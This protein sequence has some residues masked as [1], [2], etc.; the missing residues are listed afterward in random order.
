TSGTRDTVTHTLTFT[1]TPS[2]DLA[3]QQLDDQPPM[4][5]EYDQAG[6]RVRR[7]THTGSV[8]TWNHDYTGDVRSMSVDSHHIDFTH[9]LL[10][11]TTGWRTGD[12]AVSRIFTDNGYLATQE[13]IA[14]PEQTLTLDRKPNHPPPRSLRRDD[15]T[16]RPDGYFTTHTVTHPG[17]GQVHRQYSLDPRGRVAT[18][19]T[20]GVLSESY[21]YDRL[22]NITAANTQHNPPSRTTI[23]SGTD[24]DRDFHGSLLTRAGRTRYSY[25][26][27]GRLV[28]KKT[29]RLSRKPDVWHYRYNAFDQLTDVRTPDG[30]HWHYTYDAAGRRTSKQRLDS[31]NIV[32]NFA[33][34]GTTLVEDS[35]PTGSTRWHYHP[36]SVAPIARITGK[37]A[38]DNSFS[39]I[40]TDLVGTPMELFDPIGVVSISIATMQLWGST[41]WSD[42]IDPT[43]R[44]PGQLHDPETG[45]HYNLFRFY[46]P[47]TGRYLTPDPLGLAPA[48]NPSTYPHNPVAWVDPLGLAGCRELGLSDAANSAIRRFEN[49]MQD[50]VG[51]VN[52]EPNHNHYH[53]ARIEADGGVVAMRADGVPF[54]HISDLTQAR[55]GLDGI[56]RTLEREIA[57]PPDT[58]TDRGLEVLIR[59]RKEVIIQL[60]RLNGFLHSIGHR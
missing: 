41:T 3:T 19:H 16:Y 47:S 38:S 31:D 34:D 57:R 24:G 26:P 14:H 35:T 27:A 6:R 7:T 12:I 43:V 23:E 46:D 2:G 4:R 56:R 60:D 51:D 29:T 13:V 32:H 52:A 5:N 17:V 37:N 53:A 30:Q 8:T 25:D 58:L 36:D 59:K 11:R 15:Y 18:I 45:L 44:F 33:W 9:D 48:P 22:N 55:N 10:G 20:N 42:S 21:N 49:I 1:Y 50:P 28:A 39:A 54:D 40:L